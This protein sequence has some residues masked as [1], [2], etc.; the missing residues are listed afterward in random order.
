MKCRDCQFWEVADGCC[1]KKA[2]IAVIETILKDEVCL[3]NAGITVGVEPLPQQSVRASWP[4]TGREEFCG[5]FVQRV[6]R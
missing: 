2:P 1:H 5:E 3:N 6:Q 4:L